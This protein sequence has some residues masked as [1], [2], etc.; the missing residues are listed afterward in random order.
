MSRSLEFKDLFS[1]QSV[2]YARYRPS[3]PDPLFRYLSSLVG[4]HQLAWDCGTGNGQAALQLAEYFD[5]VI[6]TDPSAKQIAHATQHPKV[7]YRVDSAEKSTLNYQSVDLVTSAQ[8]F[9][10]FRQTEFFDEVHRV[11]KPQGVLAFWC[12][13]LAQIS[14]EIDQIVMKLYRDILGDYWEPER[15]QV[16]EGYRNAYLPMKEITPQ[17][18][19]M[20]AEW[21]LEH[22]VGYL[23]TWSALQAYIKKNQT[24][25]LEELFNSLQEAWGSNKTRTVKWELA[26][27]VAR[28]T[29]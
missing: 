26:L 27:R 16:E 19:E 14:P 25:P 12:Y 7:E 21:D 24:N 5:Q 28:K 10:W 20:T 15:K 11:L 4:E 29:T 1:Q 9:H 18:F 13:G 17:K 3:Y 23:N 22:L 6:A 2:D 8:A